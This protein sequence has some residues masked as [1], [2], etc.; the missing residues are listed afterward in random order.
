MNV[1]LIVIGL[2][3]VFFFFVSAV[4]FSKTR[5]TWRFLQLSGATCLLV[6]VLAH[7]A[8][9]FHLFATMGW[10]LP[11]SAGHYVDLVSAILGLILAPL[12]FVLGRRKANS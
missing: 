9:V 5:N 4:S 11:N 6:V 12:G 10:G 2:P 8:E 1:T 7:V 3:V